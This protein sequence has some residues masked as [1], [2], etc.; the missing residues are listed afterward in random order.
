MERAA[1]E[2]AM[3]ARASIGIS[4]NY[5]VL[6]RGRYGKNMREKNS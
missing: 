3:N 4:I 2:A 5:G 1:I 6:I